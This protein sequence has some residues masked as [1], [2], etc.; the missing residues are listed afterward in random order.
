MLRAC[1]L[2]VGGVPDRGE[3]LAFGFVGGG[4]EEWEE[5]C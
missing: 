5:V 2:C 4:L 1:Y 3:G